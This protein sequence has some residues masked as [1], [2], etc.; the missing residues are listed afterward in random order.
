MT[1][2]IEYTTL[3]ELFNT[4]TDGSFPLLMDIEHESINW[5]G[6]TSEIDV[7]DLEQDNCHL[8][9]INAPYAVK[10]Q[11][12][13]YLPA[14]F[15]FTPP[16]V[17]GKTIGST[18]VTI[19]AIDQRVIKIIRA[20]DNKPKATFVALFSKKDSVI[21]FSKLYRYIFE[22]NA[23]S[24]DGVSA[25]WNLVFDPAMQLQVPRDKG[26]NLRCPAVLQKQR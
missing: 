10:Y 4:D 14:Y 12:K 1:K 6:T 19:S 26:T 21:T 15:A 9:L 5:E 20:I 18:S 17:D 3:E 24:W 13:K 22:M 8:R 7:T 2:T 16:S 25:K 23:V 11:G